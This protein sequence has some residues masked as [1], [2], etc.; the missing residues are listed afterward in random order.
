MHLV[1]GQMVIIHLFFKDR[2][3][4]LLQKLMKNKQVLM[5]G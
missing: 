3:Q 2:Q 4:G 5:R 1:E